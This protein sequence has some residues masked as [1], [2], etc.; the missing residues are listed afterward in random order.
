[1]YHMKR[2]TEMERSPSFMLLLLTSCFNKTGINLISNVANKYS[3]YCSCIRIKDS[4]FSFSRVIIIQRHLNCKF[5]RITCIQGYLVRCFLQ[6]EERR[7]TSQLV[8]SSDTFPDKSDSL[9]RGYTV[10]ILLNA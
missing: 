10:F 5:K 8:F 9:V 2:L 7:V 3:I 6:I 1:M 4:L